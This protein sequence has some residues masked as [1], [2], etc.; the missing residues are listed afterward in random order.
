MTL[1]ERKYRNAEN[2][3]IAHLVAFGSH[4]NAETGRMLASRALRAARKYRD[5]AQAKWLVRH[6]SFI[7]GGLPQKRK[8]DA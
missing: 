6:C 2:N 8:G 5:R 3:L 7:T 1:N 4:N